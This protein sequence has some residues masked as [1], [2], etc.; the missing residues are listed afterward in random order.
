MAAEATALDRA[1]QRLNSTTASSASSNDQATQSLSRLN[2]E[3]ERHRRLIAQGLPAQSSLIQVQRQLATQTRQTGN[4][5]DR[6]SG[7][8]RQF[9]DAGVLLGPALVPLTT[10]AVPAIGGLVNQLGIGIL[11]AGTA[12]AAF[13]GVGDALE[14]LNEAN[15]DPTVDNLAAAEEAMAGLSPAARDFAQQIGVMRGEFRGLRD[16]A[17]SGLFPAIT[18]ELRDID[19]LLARTETLLR[20]VGE[21]AGTEVARGLDSL[22]SDRWEGFFDFLGR[23][24]APALRDLGQ[25]IGNSAH[26]LSEMW[27]AFQPLNRDFGD[28][29][30]D[31]TRRWDEWS[32]GLS[33]N[34]DFAEFLTYIR[35]NGPQVADTLG[36]I[37]AMFLDIIE[38]AAPLGGPVLA[39]L[40]AIADV[41]ST[42]ADSDIGTP[43]LSALAA[44]TL[45]NRTAAVFA[46]TTGGG[47]AGGAGAAAASGGLFGPLRAQAT[48]A[49]GSIRTLSTDLRTLG[50]FNILPTPASQAARQ[51]AMDRATQ[52]L[53]T[54]GA[55][56]GKTALGVG[57][58]TVATTGAGDSIGATNTAML[59]LAGSML[60]PYG[61][62]AG[63]TVGM[64]LDVNAAA[65]KARDAIDQVA[66]SL[67]QGFSGGNIESLRAAV[68]EIQ[69]IPESAEPGMFAKAAGVALD[70]SGLAFLPGIDGYA[71]MEAAQAKLERQAD[72]AQVSLNRVRNATTLLG[73]AME[74]PTQSTS[75]LE[76]VLAKAQPAM[77]ALGYSTID[78]EQAAMRTSLAQSQ[79]GQVFGDFFIDAGPN[80]QEIA[81]EIAEWQANAEAAARSMGELTEAYSRWNDT[82]SAVDANVAYQ[83][84]LADLKTTADETGRSFDITTQAGRDFVGG[85]TNW[86]ES[87]KA[88][89]DNAPIGE[90]AGILE[91][92]II[93]MSDAFGISIDEAWRW[94]NEVG[95]TSS[96]VNSALSSSGEESL[97]LKGF[98]DSLPPVVQ[99]DIKANGIP[100]TEGAVLRLTDKYDHLPDFKDTLLSL[101]DGAAVA[102][103]LR[104]DQLVRNIPRTW[105]TDIITR[106]RV[107]GRPAP[108]VNGPRAL[109]DGGHVTGPGGPRDDKIPAWL[110][111]GEFVI[112]AAATARHL[113]LLHAINA[114]RYADGGYVQRRPQ[115]PADVMASW[116]GASQF[117]QGGLV[118]AQQAPRVTVTAESGSAAALAAVQA[119]MSAMR[120][121][122]AALVP[123]IERGSASGTYAGTKDAGEGKANRFNQ[124]RKVT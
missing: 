21:A 29:L 73:A 49:R 98:F 65:D 36:A 77:A 10:T 23:E 38:A 37:G 46:R 102:G 54:A 43:L 24:S 84:A 119:E 68:S 109:A 66:V 120:R 108:Q 20:R 13:Q 92:S 25:A 55:V 87:V 52:S 31:I 124:M 3:H 7:R 32:Q 35:E 62:A 115:P 110:S 89:V 76:A 86:A 48:A 4:E 30:V 41:I 123:A 79:L 60:G 67:E 26:A 106:Y 56:A 22:G 97:R 74:M 117:A 94:A 95:I 51:A 104:Y 85:L 64:F 6:A 88:V 44:M 72:R 80:M 39:A 69:K 40:E 75:D 100:Q 28:W 19:P 8:L 118:A 12:V 70:Y 34:A 111:N 81:D 57:A 82:L 122:M 11:A 2:D 101:S 58:L 61:A 50:S 27:M 93:D 121:D 90:Q 91:Q 78:L 114:G 96:L 59:G 113:H 47:A 14:A 9:V 45:L 105:S 107:S 103:I 5:F 18:R 63:A 53:R 1:V 83:Q 112:N 17:A 116:Q 15:L 33:S 71:D 99:T 42:I 16:A